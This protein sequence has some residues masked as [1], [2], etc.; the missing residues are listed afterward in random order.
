V[1]V[2]EDRTHRTNS[3][4]RGRLHS[5]GASAGSKGQHIG[6]GQC[7]VKAYNRQL[8][9]LIDAGRAKPLFMGSH[10]LKLDDAPD[11]YQHFDALRHG[12]TKGVIRWVTCP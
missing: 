5:I 12:W 8:G 4:R 3:Q 10:G 9:Q 2:P 11:P 7:N 1:F 6:T